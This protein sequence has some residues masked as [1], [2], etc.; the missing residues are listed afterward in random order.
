MNLLKTTITALA[1]VAAQQGLATDFDSD[2]QNFYVD[3]QSINEALESINFIVC[4]VAAART[5]SLVNDGPYLATLYEEDCEPSAASAS[6]DSAAATKS[7]SQ[8]AST[9]TAS[10]TTT[11]DAKTAT[12]AVVAVTRLN[13]ASP[14]KAAIWFK[15]PAENPE[16]GD[17]N[18]KIYI[19]VTQYRGVSD[20]SPNGDF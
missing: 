14:A 19:D 5:D 13:S 11:V 16:E 12:E 2:R 3:G 17:I 4:T 8:S 1:L 15:A 20:T 10:T 7:S 18:E 6:D 9:A